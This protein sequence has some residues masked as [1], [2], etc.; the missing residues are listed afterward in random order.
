MI[1]KNR[2]S[3]GRYGN[4]VVGIIWVFAIGSSFACLLACSAFHG[5]N[6]AQQP[7]F[8]QPRI[9]TTQR[10]QTHKTTELV[11]W[12]DFLIELLYDMPNAEKIPP[13][14]RKTNDTIQERVTGF[15]LSDYNGE[16]ENLRC[17]VRGGKVEWACRVR[18]SRSSA[19]P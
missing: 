14:F 9:P 2:G 1:F 7:C 15:Q 3:E 13:F 11:G 12:V 4:G 8:A 18:W 5:A 10:K 6:Q 19:K 17:P 16:N